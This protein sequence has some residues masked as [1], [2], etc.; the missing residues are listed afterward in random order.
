MAGVTIAWRSRDL[1]R[2]LRSVQ[3]RVIDMTPAWQQVGE[4]LLGSIRDNFEAGGRPEPWQPL[5]ETTLLRRAGG[6]RRAYTKRGDRLRAPAARKM[7]RAKV[8]ID[9]ARLM[10]SITYQAAPRHVDVGTN[11]IYGATHQFG[12]DSGRG[13]PIPARPF[14]VIQA[15]DEPVMSG[16]LERYILEPLR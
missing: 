3:H 6:R 9:S 13:A 1:D 8:L 14:L 15:E 11:V 16:I 7:A 10:N 4:H 12:R 5:L 2:A